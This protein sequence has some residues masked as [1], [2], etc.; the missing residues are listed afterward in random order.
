PPLLSRLGRWRWPL[1]LV[2]A[3]LCGLLLALPLGSLVWR[4]GVVGT[5]PAW[6]AAATGRYLVRAGRPPEGRLL[7]DSLLLAAGSGALVATV[8]L[9][10]CWAA[11]GSRW[12]RAGVLVLIAEAWAMPGPLLG[13]GL[14]TI[15]DHLLAITDSRGLAVALYHGPSPLPLLW[16]D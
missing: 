14:K 3:V 11:R 1:A 12:F 6:S 10:T 8:G 16:V 7:L 15:I 9:L 13:L 4:A 5:P 2:A